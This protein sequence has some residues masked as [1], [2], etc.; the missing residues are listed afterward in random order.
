[1]ETDQANRWGLS[2]WGA[3]D[4]GVIES[5]AQ[6]AKP[7]RRHYDAKAQERDLH[8]GPEGETDEWVTADGE[9]PEPI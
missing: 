6:H 1:M 8:S 3:F 9:D 5:P 7:H 2:D 4:W